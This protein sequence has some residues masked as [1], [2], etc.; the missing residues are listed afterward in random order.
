VALADHRRAGI[1]QAVATTPRRHH[2]RRV[3]CGL[4]V[5]ALVSLVAAASASAR[6]L[7]FGPTTVI[8]AGLKHAGTAIGEPPPPPAAVLGRDGT[9][10]IVWVTDTDDDVNTWARTLEVQVA[11]RAPGAAS[12]GRPATVSGPGTFVDPTVVVGRDGA[13]IVAWRVIANGRSQI[14]VVVRRPGSDTFTAPVTVSAPGTL[15]APVI[16]QRAGGAIEAAW[17]RTFSSGSV[18]VIESA[19]LDASPYGYA[20]PRLSMG[21]RRGLLPTLAAASDGGLIAAWDSTGTDRARVMVASQSP[22]SSHFGPAQTLWSSR[23]HVAEIALAVADRGAAVVAW[24]TAPCGLTTASVVRVATRSTW[25]SRAWPFPDSRFG[26]TR[27]V[28]AARPIRCGSLATATNAAGAAV[29]AWT[30][31]GHLGGIEA[32]LRSTMTAPFYRPAALDAN[33][34]ANGSPHLA[35][36]ASGTATVAWLASGAESHV[37]AATRRAGETSF[38]RRVALT[39]SRPFM[40]D[41]VV[42]AGHRENQVAWRRPLGAWRIEAATTTPHR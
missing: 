2:P 5:A 7:G 3:A 16:A 11:V 8:A 1:F 22:G 19:A 39:R 34:A 21:Q 10:A 27:T 41:P 38:R 42:A 30:R 9:A 17:I 23:L 12:Y 33:G 40:S 24:D 29:V 13:V 14:A 32:A 36:A 18:F 31:F 6:P 4:A 26:A 37:R 15:S 35:M 20:A 28:A 25:R